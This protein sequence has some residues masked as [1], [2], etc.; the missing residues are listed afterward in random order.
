MCVCVGGL[1]VLLCTT[2]THTSFQCPHTNISV[3]WLVCKVHL[4]VLVSHR[5]C[6]FILRKGLK[7]HK[8]KILCSGELSR[9]KE[10]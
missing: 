5:H 4:P 6:K 7:I 9:E 3:S 2:Q 1:S 10:R 8:E